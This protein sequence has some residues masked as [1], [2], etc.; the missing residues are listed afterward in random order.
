M[1]VTLSATE[2]KNS[3]GSVIV[4]CS[5]LDLWGCA[6]RGVSGI[7]QTWV[8]R[9]SK[10]TTIEGSIKRDI[11]GRYRV[12]EISYELLDFSRLKEIEKYFDIQCDGL[13][14]LKLK[15]TNSCG[16]T[17]CDCASVDNITGNASVTMDLSNYSF[18][19]N[20]TYAEGLTVTFTESK[21]CT[22]STCGA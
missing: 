15:I 20:G 16:D 17:D 11:T 12:W 22:C 6:Y 9:G 13:A 5:S 21:S 10:H 3:S 19:D 18:A 14:C 4:P 2:L 8:V 7:S 1:Q